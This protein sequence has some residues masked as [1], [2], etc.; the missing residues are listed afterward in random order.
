LVCRRRTSPIHSF[1]MG[2]RGRDRTLHRVWRSLN[3]LKAL[4][5]VVRPPRS[6]VGCRSRSHGG[7]DEARVVL[8]WAVSRTRALSGTGVTARS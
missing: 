1:I 3:R 8:P 7:A 6:H 2:I 4:R 5:V